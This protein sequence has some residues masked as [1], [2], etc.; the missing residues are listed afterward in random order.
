M[1]EIY[2]LKA[3]ALYWNYDL[4]LKPLFK[5]NWSSSESNSLEQYYNSVSF[6]SYSHKNI[7]NLNGI[8]KIKRYFYYEI[9]D[10][11][12]TFFTNKFPITLEEGDETIKEEDIF[13]LKPLRFKWK[14]KT[15]FENI[16]IR[17]YWET[18]THIGVEFKSVG[19]MILL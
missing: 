15:G 11:N 1:I 10:E 4:F 17:L 13:E 12:T 16:K 14:L 7:N 8:P 19:S 9:M 2:P 3:S 6:S 5:R 18:V